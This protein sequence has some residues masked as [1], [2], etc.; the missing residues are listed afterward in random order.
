MQTKKS[1][2][3]DRGI[4][5]QLW[6]CKYKPR[7]PA[8]TFGLRNGNRRTQAIVIWF[9][10]RHDDIQAVSR[11]ALKQPDELLFVR[12]GSYCH[13]ALQKRGHRAEGDPGHAALLQETAPR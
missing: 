9:A 13:R 8:A 5:I 12:H 7:T 3:V 10:E 1:V 6:V 11:A 4:S 2:Q